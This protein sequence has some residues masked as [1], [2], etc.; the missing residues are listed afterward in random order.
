MPVILVKVKST[1][2][3]LAVAEKTV[4]AWIYAG[5]LCSVRLGRSVRIPQE[6]IDA[7]IEAGTTRAKSE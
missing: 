1:A 5:K 3:Q 4:W 2:S 7:L 6:V